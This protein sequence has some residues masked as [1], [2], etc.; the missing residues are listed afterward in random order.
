MS[1]IRYKKIKKNEI[2]KSFFAYSLL[3][4][5]MQDWYVVV[6]EFNNLS[7]SQRNSIIQE[8]ELRD[9]LLRE[10]LI[11]KDEDMYLTCSMVNLNIVAT[12]YDIDPATVCMCISP[13]CKLNE[14]IIVI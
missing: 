5:S 14:N 3:S 10:K 2:L 4:H 12:K 11:I 7:L 1:K 8:Q 9:S 6:K 13:L